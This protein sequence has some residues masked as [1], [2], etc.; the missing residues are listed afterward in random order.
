MTEII[1]VT[2]TY[3]YLP[4][5]QNEHLSLRR[6]ECVWVSLCWSPMAGGRR[7]HSKMTGNQHAWRGM[8][9]SSAPAPDFTDCRKCLRSRRYWFRSVSIFSQFFSRERPTTVVHVFCYFLQCCGLCLYFYTPQS[10]HSTDTVPLCINLLNAGLLPLSTSPCWIDN[11][12]TPSSR[13]LIRIPTEGT[14]FTCNIVYLA[15]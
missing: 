14:V 11:E 9:T 15:T 4:H 10:S 3:T 2:H 12:F 8:Y 7:H 5:Y 6:Q 1:L 13:Q